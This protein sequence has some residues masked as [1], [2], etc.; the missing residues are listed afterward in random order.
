MNESSVADNRLRN[1]LVQ[2]ARWH[3]TAARDAANDVNHALNKQLLV[4][5]FRNITSFLYHAH[6]LWQILEDSELGVVHLRDPEL[7]SH[8]AV[9]E[10]MRDS[11]KSYRT[12]LEKSTNHNLTVNSVGP[13]DAFGGFVDSDIFGLFD[14]STFDFYYAGRCAN[15]T[16]VASWLSRVESSLPKR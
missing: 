12:W 13:R 14:P 7:E 9:F 11:P 3:C 16:A 6:S 10:S 8:I 2:E 1:L 4:S 15:L 5:V